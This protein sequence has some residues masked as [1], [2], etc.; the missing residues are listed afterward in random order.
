MVLAYARTHANDG[1]QVK[2][3]LVGRRTAAL[4]GIKKWQTA[5]K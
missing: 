1:A 3:M 5:K 4:N 2:R